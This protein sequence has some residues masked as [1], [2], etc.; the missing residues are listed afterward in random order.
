MTAITD[1]YF[2]A[3]KNVGG[4][5]SLRLYGDNVSVSRITIKGNNGEK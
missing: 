3:F 5:L 2:F 1:D 4:Y